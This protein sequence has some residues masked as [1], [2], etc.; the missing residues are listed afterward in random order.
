VFFVQ[1][2]LCPPLSRGRKKE[3]C[4]YEKGAHE[5]RRETDLLISSPSS[6]WSCGCFSTGRLQNNLVAAARQPTSCYQVRDLSFKEGDLLVS[7]RGSGGKNIM[8]HAQSPA[9]VCCSSNLWDELWVVV[10]VFFI[11]LVYLGTT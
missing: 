9:F 3:R 7:N 8:E 10:G 5:P 1:G 6:S 4:V 2:L 11:Q